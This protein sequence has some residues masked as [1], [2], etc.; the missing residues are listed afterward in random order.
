[1]GKNRIPEIG[2]RVKVIDE[3]CGHGFNLGDKVK[4]VDIERGTELDGVFKCVNEKGAIWY[5]NI[6]EFELLEELPK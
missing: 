3:T 5:L 2:D 1:M 6:E 4:I